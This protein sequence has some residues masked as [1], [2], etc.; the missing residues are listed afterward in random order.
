M[1]NG[2][3]RVNS[4]DPARSQR[5]SNHQ[6]REAPRQ[7]S[8]RMNRTIGRL[9]GKLCGAGEG[10]MIQSLLPQL[11]EDGLGVTTPQCCHSLLHDQHFLLTNM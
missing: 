11:A 7:V 1:Q 8:D 2:E 6:S 5:F 4:Y 10:G 3:E 9:V